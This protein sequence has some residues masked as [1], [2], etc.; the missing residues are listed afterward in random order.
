MP[1][2]FRFSVFR[3]KDGDTVVVEGK[4]GDTTVVRV[5]GID[6]PESSQPYGP[7]AT[8]VARRIVGG[9]MV[10]VEV[11]DEGPYGRIIGRVQKG[12][13]DLA[14][15]LALSGYAWHSRR[16]P[17][18]RQIREAEQKARQE[19]RGLWAQDNP[20]PP[21]Q[22]RKGRQ[23]AQTGSGEHTAGTVLFIVIV[24]AILFLISLAGG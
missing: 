8:N 4:N 6:A 19:A 13:V 24:V 23:P 5:W 21:W 9:E 18:S 22:H 7:A 15:S 3:V 10:T 2:T 1:D 14:A 16:Y 20:V 11:M 12:D 17:T